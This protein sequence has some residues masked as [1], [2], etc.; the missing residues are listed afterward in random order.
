MYK[1]IFQKWPFWQDFDC[2]C[3]DSEMLISINS[4]IKII[5]AW[6][7]WLFLQKQLTHQD[8]FLQV[9]PSKDDQITEIQLPVLAPQDLKHQ[10][11]LWNHWCCSCPGRWLTHRWAVGSGHHKVLLAGPKVCGRLSGFEEK[12]LCEKRWKQHTV[13]STAPV[14]EK[15]GS[16]A[17]RMQ[18]MPEQLQ[19][20]THQWQTGLPGSGL[21]LCMG[22]RRGKE[23]QNYSCMDV[24]TY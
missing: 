15:S 12:Q 6:M 7:W 10:P 2:V 17:H 22:S 9:L 5:K 4:C 13:N 21:T 14:L 11:Y 3:L 8:C 19:A 16:S 24:C 18:D 23:R 20:P 1:I